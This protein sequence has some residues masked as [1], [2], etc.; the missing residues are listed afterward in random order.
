M[1]GEVCMLVTSIE[2]VGKYKYKVFLDMEYA[3]FLSWKELC[4]WN[5]KEQEELTQKQYDTIMH[6]AVLEKCK[7]KAIAL[8]KDK[9]RTEY[10]LRQKLLMHLY[11]HE[12]V[13]QVLDYV[14]YYH[15]IDDERYVENFIETHKR[16]HSKRWI[17]NK[18]KQKGIKKEQYDLYFQNDYCEENAIKKA[19]RKKM[20]GKNI[21]SITEK[22]KLLAYLYRQG[23][24]GSGIQKYIRQYENECCLEL[25]E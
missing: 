7:R 22:N 18:L 23:F 13:E 21:E 11:T 5:I 9:S 3:F 6:E 15:Y 4:F 2:K 24:S 10:E 14:K 25:E 16:V 12:I 19:I 1:I 17:E 8:L 20:K